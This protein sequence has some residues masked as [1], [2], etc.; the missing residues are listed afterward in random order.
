MALTLVF[1]KATY[2]PTE[3]MYA[4]L[5]S[6]P[7]ELSRVWVPVGSPGAFPSGAHFVGTGTLT[8]ADP[9]GR[10]W[11]RT[12]WVGDEVKWK[13]SAAGADGSVTVTVTYNGLS[14]TAVYAVDADPEPPPPP[15]GL[16]LRK[17]SPWFNPMKGA[18]V[19]RADELLAPAWVGGISAFVRWWDLTD[20]G[21]AWKFTG[22]DKIAAAAKKAG[23]PWALMVIL[24]GVDNGIPTYVK[25][26]VPAGDWIETDAAKFPV[27]WSV[28][29]NAYLDALQDKLAARYAADPWLA[30]VRVVGFWSTHGEPWFAGGEAG[31][32]KWRSL[33]RA[34]HPA[35]AG[36][37]D[38][39]VLTKVQDAYDVQDRAWWA[40]QA[41][42]WPARISLGAA[43]GDALY[44]NALSPAEWDEPGRHPRRLANWTLIR[45]A[46]GG[47]SVFQFNGVNAGDGASGYGIWLPRAFGPG[48][49]GPGGIAIPVARRGRIGSQPVAEAGTERLSYDGMV[50][51]IRNLTD[52]DHRYSYC[53]VY[54]VDVAKAIGTTAEG[55]K[56]RAVFNERKDAWAP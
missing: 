12:S 3:M 13:A 8:F 27:F 24:G 46:H 18:L 36:L 47:R 43:A 50:T 17:V 26:G 30:Q 7:G 19:D 44:D 40:D 54:G 25:T 35:D 41:A 51:M 2:L 37:S 28:K 20:D 22:I 1:D 53:E 42:R 45:A 6:A 14:D 29:A 16:V 11:T 10:T 4:T 48:A 49:T 23:K 34:S 52:P 32:P 21:V 33:W 31:K 15:P 56:M 38:A 39:A 9:S 5:T 55:A